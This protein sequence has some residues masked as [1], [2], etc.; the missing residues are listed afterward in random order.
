ML[1][2]NDIAINNVTG[3][4]TPAFIESRYIA[5]EL[6]NFLLDERGE[7]VHQVRYREVVTY[8]ITNNNNPLAQ[9]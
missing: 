7:D 8:L 9:S 3:A 4:I 5:Y 6:S 2:V 1:T